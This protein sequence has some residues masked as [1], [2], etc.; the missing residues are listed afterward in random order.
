M[1][2]S[3]ARWKSLARA[4]EAAEKGICEQRNMAGASM[5]RL[6]ESRCFCFFLP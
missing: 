2:N 1:R 5:R 4:E 3:P 6:I